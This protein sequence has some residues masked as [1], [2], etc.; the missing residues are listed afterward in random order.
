MEAALQPADVLGSEGATFR[1][2][3]NHCM[4]NVARLNM[5]H[6]FIEIDRYTIAVKLF[7]PIR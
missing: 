2:L 4:R 5:I 7:A 1:G 6:H 3:D